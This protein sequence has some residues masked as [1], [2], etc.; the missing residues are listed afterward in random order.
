MM[1]KKSFGKKTIYGN[2]ESGSLSVGEFS[3][4][5][6]DDIKKKYLETVDKIKDGTFI[7]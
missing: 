3:E 7:E 5:V 6:P 1:W 2:T 4:K